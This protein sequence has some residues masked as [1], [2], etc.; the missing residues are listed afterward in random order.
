[1]GGSGGVGGGRPSAAL[2]R[3][4]GTP[5]FVAPTTPECRRRSVKECCSATGEQEGV[6]FAN[7]WKMLHAV[8]A[9]RY[10]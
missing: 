4:A 2:L 9:L 5:P 1:M 6:S 8:L 7:S 10:V 3:D